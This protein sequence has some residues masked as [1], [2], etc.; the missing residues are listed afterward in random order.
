MIGERIGNYQVIRELDSG[1]MATVYLLE[2][3][4]LGTF[5]ALKVLK[6]DFFKIPNIRKRFIKEA[7]NLAKMDH[8]HIV[9]VYDLYETETYVAIVMEYLK[10]Q[11]LKTRLEQGPM[12]HLNIHQV[13]PQM[14][15]ALSYV[16]KHQLI[17]RDIKP[18]NF[19]LDVQGNCKLLDFGIAKNTDAQF[20]EYTQTSTRLAMYTPMYASPEQITETRSVT[21]QSDIYSLGVVLW[22]MVTGKKPYDSQTMNRFQMET[23]IVNQSLPPTGTGWDAVIAKATAKDPGKRFRSAAEWLTEWKAINDEP[24]GPSQ[25]RGNTSMED[26]T[27]VVSANS[28]KVD[29]RKKPKK[30]NPIWMILGILL[31]AIPI[32]VL[33][34]FEWKGG[35]DQNLNNTVFEET[36]N[37]EKIQPE[38]GYEAGY[39]FVKIGNQKWMTYN[40]DVAQFRNGD[41]IPEAKSDEEW[42]KA[43]ENGKAAWCYYDNNLENG[44]KYGKLYNWYAVNDPRGLAPEGWHVPSDSDWKILTNFLGEAESVGEKMKD[45]VGWFNNGNGTNESGLAVRPGGF[46]YG[47]G[48]FNSIGEYGSCWSTSPFRKVRAWNRNVHYSNCKVGRYS[49]GK[50][51]GSSVRCIKD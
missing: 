1:G 43:G 6:E 12:N 44:S 11:T 3:S 4:M 9:K 2:N 40:L 21:A 32:T 8:P 41:P 22:Q 51:N 45:L 38:F 42:I 13:L 27:V 19:M 20:A 28:I 31:F 24:R 47:D 25:K 14:L 15:Q 29:V 36:E 39:D 23:K 10:G 7:R 16:H 17:H 48:S 37:V 30:T 46:R 33:T 35:N 50:D 26:S 49:A 18:S 5:W 34:I